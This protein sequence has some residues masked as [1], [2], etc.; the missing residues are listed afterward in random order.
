LTIA[1]DALQPAAPYDVPAPAEVL[2]TA[3]TQPRASQKPA[4]EAKEAKE[5]K[6]KRSTVTA[7]KRKLDQVAKKKAPAF[8]AGVLGRFG[9]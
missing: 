9:R 2:E 8:G 5:A 4:K 6:G 1:V 7:R 3:Q